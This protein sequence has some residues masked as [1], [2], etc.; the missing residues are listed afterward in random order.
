[1]SD[2]YFCQK[3]TILCLPDASETLGFVPTPCTGSSAVEQP[4]YTRSV[5]GSIPS[6][7]T[8]IFFRSASFV[9]VR[10]YLPSNFSLPQSGKAN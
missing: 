2:Y 4:V 9:K 3:L 7:C 5:G 1:M 10:F 6:P 8:I